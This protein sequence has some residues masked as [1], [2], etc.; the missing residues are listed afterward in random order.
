MVKN[1]EKQQVCVI[2]TAGE[3]WKGEKGRSN[4]RRGSGRMNGCC[5]VPLRNAE[6]EWNPS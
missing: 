2:N 6:L 4:P 3:G 1:S 5:L